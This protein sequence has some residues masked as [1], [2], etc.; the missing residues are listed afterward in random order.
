MRHQHETRS[1]SRVDKSQAASA[2]CRERTPVLLNQ[3]AL[4]AYPLH[5]RKH[6]NPGQ[7]AEH[8]KGIQ[9]WP[10]IPRKRLLGYDALRL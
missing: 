3:H 4:G 1:L 6:V 5:V 8:E 2:K 7:G 10:Q 9:G